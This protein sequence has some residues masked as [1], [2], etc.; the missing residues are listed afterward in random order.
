[1]HP[2]PLLASIEDRFGVKKR[3][4]WPCMH[5]IYT[6]R[7]HRSHILCYYNCHD[8]LGTIRASQEVNMVLKHRFVTKQGRFT[9]PVR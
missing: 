1:M 5:Y 7:C 3:L 8:R 6:P 4:F 9:G 2:S